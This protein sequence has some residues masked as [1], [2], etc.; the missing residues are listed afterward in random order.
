MREYDYADVE[1]KIEDLIQT[2]RTADDMAI[3]RKMKA[4]VP[5]FLSKNSV[6]S[7]LDHAQTPS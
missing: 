4:I 5:E 6:Y 1:Q 2:A 7:S 3:V